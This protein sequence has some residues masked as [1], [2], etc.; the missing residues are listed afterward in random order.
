MPFL[1]ADQISSFM[2]VFKCSFLFFV[3][4]LHYLLSVHRGEAMQLEICLPVEGETCAMSQTLP[5][6]LRLLFTH[7]DVGHDIW[8]KTMCCSKVLFSEQDYSSVSLQE[9]NAQ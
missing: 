2:D 3:T 6:V 9:H 7:V 5:I 4:L 1:V 8:W